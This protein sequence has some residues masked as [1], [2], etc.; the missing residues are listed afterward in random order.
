MKIK[1]FNDEQE[2]FER[3]MRRLFWVGLLSITI[4]FTGAILLVTFY[5]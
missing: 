4:I 2:E 5:K 3:R 1:N